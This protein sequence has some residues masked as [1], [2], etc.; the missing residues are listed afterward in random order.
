[1]V[2]EMLGNQYFLAKKYASAA[3]NFIQTLLED[4]QNKSVRKKLIICYTQTG[5]INKAL[6]VFIELIKEDMDF[7]TNTDIKEDACPCPELIAKYGT[8]LPYESNSTDLRIMLS[9]LWLYCDAEKSL[10]FFKSL[11]DENVENIKISSIVKIIE[12][13]LKTKQPNKIN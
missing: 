3:S 4:P 13:R 6:D 10:E 12:N 11:L 1:M 5:D 2:S 8:V 9:I 7:V